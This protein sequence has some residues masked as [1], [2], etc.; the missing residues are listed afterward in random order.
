VVLGPDTLAGDDLQLGWVMS[1]PLALFSTSEQLRGVQSGFDLLGNLDFLLSG[2]QWCRSD[3]GQVVSN[4]IGVFP[5]A[6][7]GLG[8]LDGHG[9]PLS[10][11]AGRTPGP[12]VE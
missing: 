1:D 6:D 10:G 5:R 11:R 8:R 2:E 9:L 7:S 12:Q 3:L 4:Q